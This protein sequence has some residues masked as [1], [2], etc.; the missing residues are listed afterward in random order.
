MDF[1]SLNIDI[2]RL[3]RLRDGLKME[4]TELTKDRDKALEEIR[5]QRA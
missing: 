5:G 2:N 4:V 3:T 1:Q